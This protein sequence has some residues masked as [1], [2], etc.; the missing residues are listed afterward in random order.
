MLIVGCWWMVVMG[1][2]G[3]C[4]CCCCCCCCVWCCCCSLLLLLVMVVFLYISCGLFIRLF[5]HNFSWV[6]DKRQYTTYWKAWPVN[7]M[8]V[9][10]SSGMIPRCVSFRLLKQIRVRELAITFLSTTYL[11]TTP[12][13]VSNVNHKTSINITETAYSLNHNQ[14]SW[15]ELT[16]YNHK[17]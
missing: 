12:W 14:K 8:V 1:D 5:R 15:N 9:P 3:C 11:N 17:P 13:L 7:I 6:D 16:I 4:C 2:E 10:L